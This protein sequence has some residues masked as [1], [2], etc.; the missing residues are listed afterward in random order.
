M[1]Y[2][3]VA[4]NG[5][6]MRETIYRRPAAPDVDEAWDS[7]GSECEYM[8]Q[9]GFQIRHILSIVALT[10]FAKQTGPVSS[11]NLKRPQAGLG[12]IM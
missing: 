4:F 12:N 2:A 11:P 10:N 9:A 6:F 5:S 8:L 3:T 1:S 7:L